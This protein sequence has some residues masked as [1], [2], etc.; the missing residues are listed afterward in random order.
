MNSPIY[1]IMRA[2][3]ERGGYTTDAITKDI[4]TLL[5]SGALTGDEA[6]ELLTLAQDHA[7]PPNPVTLESLKELVDMLEECIVEMA[8]LL[9]GG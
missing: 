3:V 7:L 5:A 9:Y 2:R 6:Q 4:E 1:N 8:G